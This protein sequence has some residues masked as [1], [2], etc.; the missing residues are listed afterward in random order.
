[1]TKASAADQATSYAILKGPNGLRA[2]WRLLIYVA[3]LIVFGYGAFKLAEQMLHGQTP[4]TSSPVFVLVYCLILLSIALSASWIMARIEGRSL[5]VYG[6]P[7][8]RALCGQFWQ[9]AAIG[10]VSLIVLLGV[11]WL[12]G[13]YSVGSQQLHGAA[14][15]TNALLWALTVIVAAIV[16]E[17]FY[18]GYLQFTLTTGIGFW[19]AALVTSLF[20]AWV[21][22]FNPGWTWLG[23]A[24]VGGFGLIACLLLRRTG[25]LWMPIGL[26]ASWNYG[27][28]YVFGVPSSGQMGNGHLFQ[29]SFHGPS[30]ATGMPFGVEAGWPNVVL[31]LIWWFLI[32]RFLRDVKYPRAQDQV[33]TS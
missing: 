19:P 32:A 1:M 3:L 4:G 31:F 14:I 18:R 5:A 6:L 12:S 28:V 10:L 15:W 9:A 33:R 17:F 21:H 24:T 25:D 11:L 26:H 8:R 29:G 16:E 2:G 23:L 22:H 20:M 27:E 30:W 7:W 13:F